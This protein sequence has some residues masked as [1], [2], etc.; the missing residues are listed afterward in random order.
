MICKSLKTMAM[1][2]LLAAAASISMGM[3][4]EEGAI[5]ESALNAVDEVTMIDEVDEMKNESSSNSTNQSSNESST[6]NVTVIDPGILNDGDEESLTSDVD[7]MK[8][9]SSS[10]LTDQS[11]EKDVIDLSTLDAGSKTAENADVTVISYMP[12]SD[13]IDGEAAEVSDV[14]VTDV[15]VLS[16]VLDTS[17]AENVTDLSTL[18]EISLISNRTDG[19]EPIDVRV[20]GNV[21]GAPAAENVT[22]LSTLGGESTMLND[23]NATGIGYTTLS[24]TTTEGSKATDVKGLS[25]A[26]GY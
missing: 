10:N 8:N 1:V 22:N 9:A 19:A 2:C 26:L 14:E 20:L 24:E 7:E 16:N 15:R 17:A 5:E 25:E 3:A 21:L 18:G 6:E 23:D 12:P 13:S 4:S 11:S